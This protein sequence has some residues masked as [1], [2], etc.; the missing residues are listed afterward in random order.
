MSKNKYLCK[1]A[2]KNWRKKRMRKPL[3]NQMGK[4]RFPSKIEQSIFLTATMEA[5]RWWND[6]FNVY[7]GNNCQCQILW[8][9]KTDGE[10][11]KLSIKTEAE[12]FFIT[13]RLPLNIILKDV[14]YPQCKWSHLEGQ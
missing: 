11:K 1:H 8:P 4:H 10:I 7:S 3:M 9:W 13:P 14:L 6:T 12:R 5:R 2:K